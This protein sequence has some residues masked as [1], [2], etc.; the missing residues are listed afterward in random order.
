MSAEAIIKQIQKD[1][2]K[3]KKRIDKDTQKKIDQITSEI[4]QET[5]SMKQDILE[6]GKQEAENIKRIETAKAHQE[7]NRS[8]LKAKEQIIDTCFEQA[9]QQLKDLD[10]K[11]YSSM[12]RTLIK[13]GGEKITCDFSIKRSKTLDETIAKDLNIPVTGT[14][15]AS[16]GIILVSKDESRTIDNTFEGILKRKKQEIRVEVGSI[17]F[18]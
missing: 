1:A 7:A 9:L 5:D 10:D 18:H 14:I 2:E 3:E 13:K 6:K 16:G 12:I 8:L 15:K 17:L 11:K 4:K